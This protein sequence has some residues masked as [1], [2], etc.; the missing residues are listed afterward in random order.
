[1][2]PCPYENRSGKNYI[3]VAKRLIEFVVVFVARSLLSSD[4]LFVQIRN[5]Y[6]QGGFM[7]LKKTLF[8]L[9]V[10]VCGASAIPVAAQTTSSPYSGTP[11][12]LPA[13]STFEASKFDKGGQNVAYKD[14]TAGNAGGQFRTAED[15]DITASTDAQGGPYAIN[16]FQTGEWLAYSVSDPRFEPLHDARH[17]PHGGRRGKRHWID[18]GSEHR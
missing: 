8:V 1:M 9:A 18:L 7:Q 13:S 3:L 4:N 6:P 2:S 11:I 10:I 16:N 14:L 15:V 17:V 12:A 5:T